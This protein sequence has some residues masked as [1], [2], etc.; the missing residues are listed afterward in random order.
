MSNKTDYDENRKHKC[1]ICK[2]KHTHLEQL[3]DHY[4]FEHFIGGNTWEDVI[5]NAQDIDINFIQY[6][7]NTKYS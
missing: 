3:A 5:K 4:M 2:S 1:I 6:H 7:R